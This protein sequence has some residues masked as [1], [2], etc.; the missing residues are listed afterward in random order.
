MATQSPLPP[1]WTV[2][3]DNIQETLA[4]A[5]QRADARE[6]PLAELTNPPATPP[7]NSLGNHLELLASRV[8]SIQ[9]PLTALDRILQSEEDHVRSHLATLAEL[10]Q[11]L[12]DWARGEEVKV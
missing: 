11:K 8:E 3:L 12:T 1:N 6:A 7:P 5:I 4:Q 9:E 2:V 10:R